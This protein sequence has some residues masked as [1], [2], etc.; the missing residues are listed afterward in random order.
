MARPH[1]LIIP[2]WFDIDFN[3]LF[4]KSYHRWAADLVSMGFVDVG[5]LYGEFNPGL[6]SR[7][8]FENSEVSYRYLGVKSWGLPK[9]GVGWKLWEH[10]YISAFEDYVRRYG[11]PSVIHG[12]SL[13]GVIAANAIYSKHRIPFVYTEVLGSMISGDVAPRLVRKARVGVEMAKWVCGISPGMANAL[14]K[15]FGIPVNLLSLYVD[16]DQFPARP[17]PAVPIRFISIGSPARTKGMDVLIRAMKQVQ[18]HLPLSKLTIVCEERDLD[19]LNNL[20][21]QYKLQG[22]VELHEP[23]SYNAIP[24]LLHGA[25][26]LVSASREES[27]GYTMIEALSCG[28]PVIASPTSGAHFIVRE[29]LGRIVKTSKGKPMS[30]LS[31]ARTMIE[32]AEQLEQYDPENLH[33]SVQSRFG[34][35]EILDQ[36]AA[37]YTEVSH[38]RKS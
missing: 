35:K 31:L 30:S 22:M 27:L 28:R 34:K 5:L 21:M 18:D 16:G 11:Q 23:V 17:F 14:E 26:I 3:H 32:T 38:H 20:T 25:H 36:W 13:L 37:I 7:Q 9:A 4:S 6:R 2:P 24:A 19:D 15:R 33:A 12:F 29:G 10:H 1:V 8:I